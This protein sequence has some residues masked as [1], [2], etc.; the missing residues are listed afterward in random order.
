MKH[1][2]LLLLIAAMLVVSAY[3]LVSAEVEYVGADTDTR[4]DWTGKYGENG[5]ILFAIQ[6]LVDLKVITEFDDGGNQRWDWENPTAD[7][8]GP[9]YLDDPGQRTGSCVFN[10]PVGVFTIETSLSNYQVAAYVV[11]WDSSVRVQDMVGFQGDE[12]PGDPDVTV[13]NPE[14]NTGMYHIWHVSGGE[15][16]KLQIT[17]Q[18]GA[19]WVMSGIF[20]DDLGAATAVQAKGR[21]AATWG[22]LRQ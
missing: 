1:Q 22:R 12:A 13:E 9:V 7:E 15:P 18:G 16:F 10:N 2:W 11:D 4:G 3:S 14:F 17:H 8:R 19:N 6:D 20:V 21:L 5:V